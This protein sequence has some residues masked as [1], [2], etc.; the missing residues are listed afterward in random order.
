MWQIVSWHQPTHL[1]VTMDLCRWLWARIARRLALAHIALLL[2]GPWLHGQTL[3]VVRVEVAQTRANRLPDPGRF[4]DVDISWR[5]L[6]KRVLHDQKDI[7]LFP[8]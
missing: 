8:T 4:Q 2:A 3:P 5:N 6:P 7:W 1:S